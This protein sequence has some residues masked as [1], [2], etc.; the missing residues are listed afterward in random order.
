MRLFVLIF[1]SSNW[2][3]HLEPPCM[4]FFFLFFFFALINYL[5]TIFSFQIIKLYFPPT[6]NPSNSSFALILGLV[7]IWLLRLHLHF[8]H[9]FFTHFGIMRLLFMHCSLNS[10]RKY[11]LFHSKQCIRALF[12][13]PQ[14]PLSTTFSLKIGLTALFTHLKIILLQCF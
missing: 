3:T 6:Q 10:S 1:I 13:D 7:W 11:W 4:D 2:G 12:T 14:I 5:P 9:F 8:Q